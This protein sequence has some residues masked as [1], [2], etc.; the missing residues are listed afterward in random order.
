MTLTELVLGADGEYERAGHTDGVFTTERPWQV[1]LDLPA[2][3]ARRAAL[4]ERDRS[5]R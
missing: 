4:L 1:T 3:T 5:G 2:L